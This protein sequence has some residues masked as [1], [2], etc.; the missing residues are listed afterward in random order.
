MD[1]QPWELGRYNLPSFD[2]QTPTFIT[3]GAIELFIL[4]KYYQIEVAAVDI[5]SGR[6]DIY[7]QNE[8]YLEVYPVFC[9]IFKSSHF[10]LVKRIYIIYDGIHYG[11]LP[12][13]K[14]CC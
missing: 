9:V 14:S 7:G 12:P 3:S 4:S 5:Q 8:N 2:S 13:P 11:I 1:P 10:V 6:V